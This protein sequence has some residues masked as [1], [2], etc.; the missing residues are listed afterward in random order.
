M[1]RRT[2]SDRITNQITRFLRIFRIWCQKSTQTFFKLGNFFIRYLIDWAKNFWNKTSKFNLGDSGHGFVTSSL[3]TWVKR[4][5][6]F[7]IA[8]KLHCYMTFTEVEIT[9]YNCRYNALIEI[10]ELIFFIFFYLL[11]NFEIP[12]FFLLTLHQ[13]K[14]YQIIVHFKQLQSQMDHPCKRGKRVSIKRKFTHFVRF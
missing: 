7:F 10:S 13:I 9:I 11:I 4:N 12:V 8:K 3:I 14:L 1:I 6:S 2:N 5:F